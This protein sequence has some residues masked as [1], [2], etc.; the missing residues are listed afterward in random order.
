MSNDLTCCTY[1]RGLQLTTRC[2]HGLSYTTFAYANLAVTASHVIL[3]VTNTGSVA[4]S[5]AVQLY[6]AADEATSSIRR[7]KK[8]LKGFNKVH[9]QPGETR[10]VEI[11]LDR[12]ATAF[13]DEE[14]SCWVCEKGVYKVL[15]G[16]SSQKIQLQGELKLKETT[17]WS[18]L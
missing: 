8:E 1:A 10:R 15:V 6:I 5:E 14:L 7:P 12:F 4:G 18:G 3:D 16:S 17:M 11:A 9:L 13:W 2:S